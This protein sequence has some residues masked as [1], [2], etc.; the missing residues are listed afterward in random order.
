MTHDPD[1]THTVAD[2]HPQFVLQDVPM[3][4]AASLRRS[5][6]AGQLDDQWRGEVRPQR[7]GNVRDRAVDR[8]A[9]ARDARR[10][11]G[12]RVIEGVAGA[13]A[14]AGYALGAAAQVEAVDGPEVATPPID[15]RPLFAPRSIA[16]VG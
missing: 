3:P 4:A 16:V 14:L 11:A 7:G 9:A 8:G 2:R 5:R 12:R 13:G 10:R 1:Y 6:P 15:L